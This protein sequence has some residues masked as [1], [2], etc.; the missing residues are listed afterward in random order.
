[1]F[2]YAILLQ[3]TVNLPCN[4]FFINRF[5]ALSSYKKHVFRGVVDFDKLHHL[6]FVA[7][8]FKD[9]GT[10]GVGNHNRLTLK[11]NAVFGNGVGFARFLHLATNLFVT[12]RGADYQFGVVSDTF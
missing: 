2:L 6:S 3:Q 7:A 8:I 4:C 10:D 11:E 9:E 12:A 5:V 1:M